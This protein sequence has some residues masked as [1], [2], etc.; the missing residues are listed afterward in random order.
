MLG[1]S[2]VDLPQVIAEGKAHDSV[3]HGWFPIAA[4]RVRL[5]LQPGET[6]SLVKS[7]IMWDICSHGRS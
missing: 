4:N 5:E 3:A 7:M 1:L 6:A 2:L